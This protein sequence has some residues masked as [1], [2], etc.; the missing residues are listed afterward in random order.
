MAHIVRIKI[1]GLLGRSEPI[2]L[3]LD[4]TV[5][6]FFG[7]N[8]CGKT[9]LLKILQ[10]ALML[11]G[12]LMASLPVERA[13]VDIYSV[14]DGRVIPYVWDRKSQKNQR[15]LPLEFMNLMSENES[16]DKLRHYVSQLPA[17]EWKVAA[18]KKSKETTL[19]SWSHC[20]LPTTRLYSS[21]PTRRPNDPRANP[22]DRLNEAFAEAVNK[23]WLSYYNQILKEVRTIQEQGLRAVLYH[24]LSLSSDRPLGPT[25]NPEQ[26]YRS[27]KKFLER[28]STNDTNLLGSKKD[29]ANRYASEEAL[30][31]VVDNIN[32]VESRIESSMVPIHRFTDTVDRLFSRDKK[33][34]TTDGGLAV[35]L[36]NGKLI[37]PAL[38]SSGEKHLLIILLHS[39]TA[40]GN[41]VIID[42]PELSMHIDWQHSLTETINQ[43]NPN[44]QLILASHSPEIM[45]NVPDAKIF[46]I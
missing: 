20:F 1:E 10:S 7:E 35:A 5:N 25:L 38:L 45:A 40:A 42:E 26:A 32:N 29:F 30:R 33:L 6:V 18:S 17:L 4:R 16:F 19:S 36:A 11:D 21:D 3:N 37:T 9:T 46:R 22:E 34:K 12:S 31:K 44:C 28:Q 15:T 8:G 27:V 14:T 24:S 23:R 43:L 39:M 2:E 13:E 41:S